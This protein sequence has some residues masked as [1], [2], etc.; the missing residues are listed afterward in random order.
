M[1]GLSLLPEN[2]D[3]VIL[4]GGLGTRLR[5]SI[6]DKP[7]SLAPI[8]DRPFVDILVDHLLSF[9]FQRFVLCVGHL[10][11]QMVCHFAGRDD[12]RIDFSV[13]ETPLG[14]GGAVKHAIDK[15]NSDIFLV[16][17]GDSFCELEYKDFLAFHEAKNASISI[18]VAEVDESRDF[19]SIILDDDCR[20]VSFDEKG[21][22][23][24]RLVNAGIYIFG[25]NVLNSLHDMEKV[26]SL[27]RDF[28]PKVVKKLPSY[29][30]KASSKLWDIGTPERY[31]A[32]CEHYSCVSG[33]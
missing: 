12:C 27:E 14:T 23:A 19:G 25:R 1:T 18:A 20:I 3:V 28:F 29:G 31:E 6:A 4:A 10:K 8:N 17:N 32:F 24:S 21:K 13:E 26:F 33:R 2:M 16:L 11:E 22:N 5:P 9:G 30:Y 15:I 7:K